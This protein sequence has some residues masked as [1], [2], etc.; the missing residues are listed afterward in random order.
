MRLASEL[1]PLIPHLEVRVTILG[2]LQRG[3]SP[4]AFDRLLATRFGVHAAH[5]VMRGE[6]A[7]MAALRGNA[8][9]SVPIAEVAGKNKFIPLDHDLIRAAKSVG[10]SFGEPEK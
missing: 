9:V 8:I 10:T 4:I 5:M 2:H 7:K 6:F 3:G 1:E